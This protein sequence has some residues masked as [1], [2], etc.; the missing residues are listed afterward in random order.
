ML[1]P[2]MPIAAR[3]GHDITFLL[4][5]CLAT[6][7]VFY[8]GWPLLLRFVASL[9]NASPNMFTLIGLGVGVAYLFSLITILDGALQWNLFPEELRR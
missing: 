4:Q 2:G 7:I 1:L 6:P 8:C 9:R 5:A 3:L